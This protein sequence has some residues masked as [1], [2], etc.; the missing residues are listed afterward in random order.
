[1]LRTSKNETCLNENG[2]ARWVRASELDAM[3]FWN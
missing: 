1:M 3:E 2:I